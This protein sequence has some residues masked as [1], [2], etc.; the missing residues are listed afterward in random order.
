MF[1]IGAAFLCL[2]YFLMAVIGLLIRSCWQPANMVVS[3]PEA[4]CT[5]R[6]YTAVYSF[7]YV[8]VSGIVLPLLVIDTVCCDCT[9]TMIV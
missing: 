3:A 1:Y 7:S 5:V 6:M 2:V 8:S 4:G 9:V